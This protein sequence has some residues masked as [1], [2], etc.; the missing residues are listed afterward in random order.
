MSLKTCYL[1]SDHDSE[2]KKCDDLLEALAETLQHSRRLGEPLAQ[3]V[4]LHRITLDMNTQKVIEKK[5]ID[6]VRETN[7]LMYGRG[8]M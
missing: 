5:S 4:R 8:G 2:W 7:D 3:Y 1:I 6:W